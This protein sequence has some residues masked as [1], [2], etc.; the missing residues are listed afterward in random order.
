MKKFITIN[1]DD[2]KKYLLDQY[3]ILAD[4]LN[5]INDIREWS[6]TFWTGVNGALLGIVAYIKDVQNV[7]TDPKR[8]FLWTLILLGFFICLSWLNYLFTI[9]KSVDIRNNM[10]IEF[11]KYFPAKPFTVAISTME[12]KKGRGSLSLKEMTVPL[13]FLIGYTFFGMTLLIYPEVVVP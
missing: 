7:S 3:K 4:S 9:K 1:S 12:R 8:L 6:N 2:D 5:K 13:L 11:E 10:L